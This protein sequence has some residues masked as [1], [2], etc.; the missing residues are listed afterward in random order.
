VLNCFNTANKCD[1]Q[2][3][4]PPQHTLHSAHV[5]KTKNNE[6]NMQMT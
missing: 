1:R 6:N 2:T 5:A 4:T 3:D